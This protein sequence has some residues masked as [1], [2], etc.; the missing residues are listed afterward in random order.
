MQVKKAFTGSVPLVTYGLIAAAVIAVYTLL[1]GA[2]DFVPAFFWSIGV[3]KNYDP[4]V[5]RVLF[6]AFGHPASPRVGMT[7]EL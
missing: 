6:W 5:Y 3:I 2:I 7:V 4:E 1:S